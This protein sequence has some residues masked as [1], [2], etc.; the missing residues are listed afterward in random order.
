MQCAHLDTSLYDNPL[1]LGSRRPIRLVNGAD[2]QLDWGSSSEVL[3]TSIRRYRCQSKGYR[4]RNLWDDHYPLEQGV[5]ARHLWLS[6][7]PLIL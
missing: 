4:T 5:C 6:S 1:Q 3:E 2:P 7:L